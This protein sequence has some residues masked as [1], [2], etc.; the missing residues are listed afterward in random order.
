M[1]RT[2]HFL[3]NFAIASAAAAFVGDCAESCNG[4]RG[5]KS[6]TTPTH[7]HAN[8]S[9]S[10]W[11][12]AFYFHQRTTNDAYAFCTNPHNVIQFTRLMA[13]WFQDS[14]PSLASF[15]FDLHSGSIATN[16]ECQKKKEEKE[17]GRQLRFLSCIG[18]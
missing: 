12:L 14:F 11:K 10:T 3:G 6:A 5:I 8:S 2:V 7:I 15:T 4:R 1:T 13:L 18:H 16:S 9:D 17:K